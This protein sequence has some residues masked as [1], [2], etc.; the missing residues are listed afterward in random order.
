[1]LDSS[2]ILA[3]EDRV[4]VPIRVPEWKTEVFI[5]PMSGTERDSFEAETL[6][7][8]DRLH[9]FRARLAVRVVCNAAGERLFTDDQAE[10]LGD[11]SSS[12][13]DRI[14]AAAQKMNRIGDEEVSAAGKDSAG[15][16]SASSGS[17]SP[18]PSAI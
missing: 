16:Q 3:I 12:A 13:L 4:L 7:M 5:R 14:F 2:A 11:K 6:G 9:N 8:K 17:G 10:A 18:S 15:D 1:M